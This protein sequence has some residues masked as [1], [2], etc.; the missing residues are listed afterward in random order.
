MYSIAAKTAQYATS[1]IPALAIYRFLDA[2]SFTNPNLA[3]SGPHGALEI[4]LAPYTARP[5]DET[6]I[7]IATRYAKQRMGFA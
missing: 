5:V 3:V 1:L 6:R 7:H 4:D 2:F